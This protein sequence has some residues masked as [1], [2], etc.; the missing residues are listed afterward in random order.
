M[1][2]FENLEEAEYEFGSEALQESLKEAN[3][4]LP[5]IEEAEHTSSSEINLEKTRIKYLLRE[6][7]DLNER[8]K[9]IREQIMKHEK[10]VE[11]STMEM[12]DFN[13]IPLVY[14]NSTDADNTINEGEYYI[15][16]QENLNDIACMYSSSSKD[17]LI[18][19]SGETMDF[20]EDLEYFAAN[21]KDVKKEIAIHLVRN[22]LLLDK[23]GNDRYE[24]KI[25]GEFEEFKKWQKSE[26]NNGENIDK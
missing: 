1:D 21:Y 3:S 5:E 23:Y 20:P 9:L 15:I 4:H 10:A 22:P 7:D 14:C 2:N 19:K 11:I 26:Q 17:Y 24:K 18:L 12:I 6:I 13:K 8:Q 25:S 16:S